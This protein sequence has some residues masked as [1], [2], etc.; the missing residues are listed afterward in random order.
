MKTL[1]NLF[2]M[3]PAGTPPKQRN[4][5]N[6]GLTPLR[7][8]RA[9]G[10]W[11]IPWVLAVTVWAGAVTEASAIWSALFD[12]GTPRNSSGNTP[13]YYYVGDYLTHD[14]YWAFNE[15][16]GTGTHNGFGIKPPSGSWTYYSAD[17]HQ[18]NGAND[19]WKF[20]SDN[21]VQFKTSGNHYYGGRF[22]YGW[23]TC[24][25]DSDWVED[26][27]SSMSDNS[28]FT[29]SAL[30]APTFSSAAKDSTYPS[31]K[32]DLAW[33][34]W[35]SKNVLIVRRTGSDVAWTPTPGATYTDGENL[36]SDTY[37]VKGSWSGTSF[38]DTVSGGTTYYYKMFSENNHYYSAAASGSKS[39][40]T[41]VTTYSWRGEANTAQWDY[42][43]TGDSQHWWDG[44]AAHN[45]P[46]NNSIIR[47][48]NNQQAPNW[49]Q[50][51]SG[52]I[53]H[54][55]FFDD[56]ATT[57]RTLSDQTLTLTDNGGTDPLIQNDSTASHV[58][59]VGLT[60]DATDPMSIKAV[61]GNLT[62][63]GA[64]ANAGQ[65]LNVD[66]ASGKTVTM[67]TGVVSG[68]GGITKAGT[69]TLTLSGANGYTGAIA[70][71][72]GV[73]SAAHNT[74]LGTVAGG[75]TV[76]SGTALQL[77]GG[78]T[79]GAEALSLSGTGVSSAGALRN[80]SGNNTYGGAVTLAASSSVA[81]DGASD[82]LTLSGVVHATASRTLTKIG[83]G[84]LALTANNTFLSEPRIERGTLSIAAVNSTATANQPL[85]VRDA[86]PAFR[87][88]NDV[89]YTGSDMPTLR[90]TG[91]TAS[92]PKIVRIGNAG[93]CAIHVTEAATALT[94]SGR[95]YNGATAARLYKTGSGRLILSSSSS[96][97]SGNT[98]IT[99]GPL[100]A[101]VAEALGN[102][103]SGGNHSTRVSAGGALEIA[104]GITLAEEIHL[105]SDGISS[106]G[107]LR[108]ISGDNTLSGLF[109]LDGASRINSDS[110]T[111]TISGAG[112]IDETYGLTFGG[113]G[114][115]T[116][117]TPINTGANTLTKDGSGTL[118]LNG[119][120]T[121]SG[122]TTISAGTLALGASGT[123]DDTPQIAIAAG[124]T[125]DI[126][127]LGSVLTRN[128]LTLQGPSAS[129]TGAIVAGADDGLTLGATSTTLNLPY[130]SSSPVT[131]PLSITGGNLTLNSA[132]T[133]TVHNDGTALAAGAGDYKIISKGTGGAV[134][135]TTLPSVTVTGNGIAADSCATL[136]VTSGEL[137]IRV[138]T[139]PAQ[140]GT[141]TGDASVCSGSSGNTYSITT[142]SGATGY[143]WAVPS[144]ASITAGQ[145]TTEITVTMGSSSGNISVTA[146]NSCGSSSARTLAVT[147]TSVPSAP[148]VSAESDVTSSGFTANWA[149]SSG[150]TSYELDVMT[151][152][153]SAGGLFISEVT[154][155]GDDISARF[156]ELYNASGADINFGTATWYLSKQVNGGTWYDIQ[157][158]GIA[159]NGATFI[160]AYSVAGFNTAYGEDPEQGHGYINANGDDAY[161][162]YS[163]DDH[164]A[165]TLVDIY[166]AL[167]T[168]GTGE[169]WEYE[170]TH[171]VRDSDINSGSTTWTASEWT[172]PA[173]ADVADMTPH[174]HTVSG[175][176]PIY[177]TSPDYEDLALG[178]VTT[179]PVIG[180]DPSSTYFYWV[181][182][183]N[184][185]GTSENSGYQ[186]VD[187][188]TPTI[189]SSGT[190]GAL[191]T[192]YGTAS[193][194][195]TTFSVS[196]ANM[197]AGILVTPP[198]GFEVSLSSGSGFGATVTVGSSGTIASTPVYLRLSATASAG[199]KSGNIV[200]SSS[201][202]ASANVATTA[203]TIN[204]LAVTLTGSRTYDG[205]T[206]AVY[207]ILTV[208]NQVGS[209]DVTVASGTA[210]LASKNVGSPSISSPGTLALGGADQANYTLTGASGSA[211]IT[212]RALT[213]TAATASKTYDGDTTSATAATL[214]SGVIQSGDSAP[215]WTQSYDTANVGTSKT[216][217][218]SSLVVTDGNSGNNY[219]YTYTPDTVGTITK[220]TP[221]ITTWP[222]ASDILQGEALSDSTLSGGS[223]SVA[224]SFAFISP[225]TT[226]SVGTADQD[227]RFTPTDSANYNTVDDVV[228][229]TVITGGIW[230][231]GGGNDDWDTAANW[232]NDT[233][234]GS[235]HDASFYTGNSSGSSIALNTTYS[236]HSMTFLSGATTPLSFSGSALTIGADGISV[237]AS[238]AAHTFANNIV[239]DGNQSWENASTSVLTVG[240]NISGA[241]SMDKTGTGPLTL[242][243]DNSF[244]GGLTLGGGTL[245]A[246]SHANA[247]GAGD[248]TLSTA[249]T[250]LELLNDTGLTFGNNT[251]VSA[252][253]T[254]ESGRSTSGAGVTHT[255]GTLSMAGDTL[256]VNDDASR[257]SGTAGLTFGT[258][259]LSADDSVFT[260]AADAELT[261][262]ALG[263]SYTWTKSGSG[264]LVLSA[265]AN[266]NSSVRHVTIS[267]GVVSIEDGDAFGTS[268]CD[269]II[270]S[271]GTLE[272]NGPGLTLDGG[273]LVKLND[274]GTFRSVGSNTSRP[275][276][277]IGND[278]TVTLEAAGAS[279]VFT[280]GNGADDITG[281]NSASEIQIS[282]SGT[283][284]LTEDSD[285]I[286]S[287]SLD[288]GTLQI[289]DSALALGSATSE[290]LTLN[291][292]ALK[293]VFGSADSRDF[294]VG[295]GN[296]VIVSAE[297][298]ITAD[299]DSS[300]A[301][302]YTFGT[303]S[304]GAQTLSLE[305][306]S[307]VSSGTAGV[308]FGAI[309]LTGAPTFDVT[310]GGATTEL[311]LGAIDNGVNLL[312]VTGTGDTII[313]GNVGSGATKSGGLT[314]SGTGTLTMSAAS[315][316]TGDTTITAGTLALSTSG[317][318]AS[319]P[320]IAIS[321]GATFSVA[322]LS[323]TLTLASGQDLTIAGTGT[324]SPSTLTTDSGINLATATDSEITFSSFSSSG[325]EPL[326]VSGAGSLTLASGNTVNVTIT[327]GA[328]ANGSYTLIAS[329]VA[330][331]APTTVTLGGDGKSDGAASAELEIS[332][333]ALI[334]H[335]GRVPTVT[336]S[337]ATGIDGTGATLN[338]NVTSGNGTITERGFCYKT[339]S[340]VSISDNKTVKSGTT[341][342]FTHDLTTLDLN[343]R[344][345]WVAYAMNRWGTTLSTPELDFWTLAAAPSAPTV[346]AVSS[347]S[348]SVDVNVNG[349]S[350]V[351]E[352]AI[353]ETSG[354]YVQADGTLDT[355]PEWQTDATWG[356]QNVTGLTV[357]Q[358]Y[359][360][361]VIARNGT[362]GT[363]GIETAFSATA[364]LYTLAIVPSAPTVNNS[365]TSSLDVNVNANGNPVSVTFAIYESSTEEYVQDD[366]TLGA[367]E[368]WQTEAIW[369]TLT[370]TDLDPDTEYTFQVK[371]KNGDGVETALGTGAS[372]STTAA[373]IGEWVGGGVNGN[374]GTA[375]NWSSDT[376]PG[377]SDT[378][379]FY[380]R[381][382][383]GTSLNLEAAKSI[384]GVVFNLL[385]DDA[386]T[387]SGSALTIGADG[388][389]V[390]A[391]AAGAHTFNN[392]IVL[393]AAQEWALGSTAGLTFGGVISGDYTLTKTGTGPLNLNGAN[394][395]EDTLTISAGLVTLGNNAGLGDTA[396]GT[397]V[398]S[399]AALNLNGKTV[400]AEALTLSG[401][402]ISSSGVLYNNSATAASVSGAITLDANSTLGVP[403]GDLTLSGAINEADGS[404][405]VTK[406][407]S[408]TLILSGDNS[409]GG[410]WLVN[411][412]TLK[413]GHASA[414]GATGA[415]GADTI[416]ASGAVLDLNG[417]AVGNSKVTLNGTGISSGGALINSSGTAASLGTQPVTLGSASSIGG[418]GNI[419][420][421]GVFSGSDTLTK[422]GTGTV[423]LA[424]ISS[425]FSSK[426]IIDNGTLEF[427]TA[428]TRLGD[429]PVGVVADQ[430]T[431]NGATL[432]VNVGSSPSF[433]A[434]RGVT[435]GAG[436]ATISVGATPTFTIN[437]AVTGS[438]ALT[439]TGAGVLVLTADNATYSG[440]VTV[441]TGTLR[442]GGA[443]ALSSAN[444]VTVSGTSVLQVN[445]DV[446]IGA[447]TGASGTALRK[448]VTGTQ[449]LT[450]SQTTDTTFAGLIENGSGTLALTKVGSGT[451]T[452]SGSANTYSGATAINAGTLLVSGSSASSAHTVGAAGT[453]A[454]A[455]TV[456][457]L[458][459]NG[460]VSPGNSTGAESTLNAAAI[461]LGAGG[462]YTFDIAN[463]AGTPGT[464]W[465]L[466][467]GTGAL[468]VNASGT[469]TIYLTGNPTGFSSSS[470]YAWTILS[471][472]SVSGF[473]NERFAV[474]VTGFTPDLGTGQF[475]VEQDG[476][477]IQLVFIR[478]PTE[479]ANTVVFTSRTVGGMTVEW[480]GGNGSDSLVI[481]RADA[482][483]SGAP[484][485]GATGYSA[486]SVF[487]GSGTALGDGKIVYMG[488]GASVAVT[489]LAPE[490]E[491][492]A[493]VFEFNGSGV[494]AN[495]FTGIGSGNPNSAYTLS[496]EPSA[497]PA[498]FT[499]T[500]ASISSIN[501][502]WGD[503]TG[504]SGFIIVRQTADSGWT[505]PVG[506]TVYAQGDPL[507][508]GGTVVYAGTADGSGSTTDSYGTMTANTPYYYKIYAYKYDDEAGHATYNYKTDSALAANATTHAAQPAT[509]AHDI[510]IGSYAGATM[511][512]L[513]WTDGGGDG[514]ILVVKEGSEV[515]SFPLDGATYSGNLTFGSG[516]QIGTGN[517]VVNV[518]SGPIT[519]LSG[520]T[521]DTIYHFR[522]FEYSGTLGT[523]ANFLTTEAT[524]NPFS[525]TTVA[526]TPSTPVASDLVADP[527]GTTTAT[528]NW[529]L[530]DGTYALV[531]MKATTSA[532][533]LENPSD[534]TT[535]AANS[536]LGSG[537][538]LGSDTFVVYK[539]SGTSVDVSNLIPGTKYY[540]AVYMFNGSSDGAESYRT[541]DKPTANF[542][543][544]AAEPTQ[545]T[546]ITFDNVATTSMDVEWTNGDG[547]GRIVVA[548]ELD[549]AGAWLM[550]EG[551]GST[552][553]DATVNGNDG[554]FV[555]S[556]TWTTRGDA[557]ALTF[558]GTSQLLEVDDMPLGDAAPT[559]F[560]V[561]LWVYS[562]KLDTAYDYIVFRG[563]NDGAEIGTSIYCLHLH[564]DD[565]VSWAVD[566]RLAEGKTGITT[567]Q[568]QNQWVHMVG[569]Y[570]GTASKFYLNGQLVHT[571][572]GVGAIGNTASGNV[573]GFAGNPGNTSFR[574]FQGSLSEPMIFDRAL[575]LTEIAD[576]YDMTSTGTGW[577]PTDGVA[578]SGVDND[579]SAATDQG[580]NSKIVFNETGT[581]NSVTVTDLNPDT[582]YRFRV[583]EY[584]GS[585]SF[586]NYNTS[587]ATDNPNDQATSPLEPPTEP[588]PSLEVTAWG[589][590]SL[591]LGWSRGNGNNVLV[592]A[593]AIDPA[594]E[595]E[596]DVDYTANATLGS[597]DLVDTA[598]R[599]VYNGTG[600][601]VPVTG[602]SPASLYQF[603]AYEYLDYGAF[604]IRYR[605]A[606]APIADRYT[607]STEPANPVTDFNANATDPASS[608]ELDLTWV[609]SGG[610]PAPDGYIILKRVGTAST[611]A[612]ADGQGYAVGDAVGDG[613]VAAIV[614][615]GTATSATVYGLGAGTA[616]HFTIFPFRWKDVS[617]PTTC[618]Y[619]T[620]GTIPTDWE[621]TEPLNVIKDQFN[622]TGNLSGKDGDDSTST[623]WSDAWS[624]TYP[625]TYEP[626]LVSGSKD[627]P[628]GYPAVAGN[629]VQMSAT[630][631]ESDAFTA[632]RPF[633]AFTS[634]K[635][636]AAA[637]MSHDKSGAGW[638]CGLSLIDT[639]DGVDAERAFMGG[640]T[641]A[642]EVL[643]LSSHGATTVS[644]GETFW[645]GSDK[646]HLVI[647]RYDFT[648]K[649]ISGLIYQYDGDEDVPTSEPETW[650]I[651]NIDI[652]DRIDSDGINAVQ[653]TCGGKGNVFQFDEVR[654]A[655]SWAAIVEAG[656]SQSTD[657]PSVQAA[658]LNVN[659]STIS[660]NKMTL[661][662]NGGN[663][664]NVLVVA[665]TA[666][667]TWTPT[668]NASYTANAEYETTGTEVASGNG[669]YAIYNGSDEKPTINLTELEK[670][671]PYY[672]RAFEYNYE[673]PDRKYLKVSAS[674]NPYSC[675]TLG[676][677]SP[678][679]GMAGN[680]A[681]NLNWTRFVNNGSPFSVLVAY[682]VGSA[683]TFAP[684]DGTAY[685]TGVQGSG[686]TILLANEYDSTYYYHSGF[687]AGQTVHYKFFTRNNNYYSE[688]VARSVSLVTSE[689]LLYDGCYPLSGGINNYSGT[690]GTGWNGNWGV[691]DSYNDA[692]GA[693]VWDSGS[694][695]GDDTSLAAWDSDNKI[696]FWADNDDRDISATRYI[697]DDRDEI[698]SGTYYLSFRM[699]FQYGG[700]YNYAGLALINSSGN[701]EM[702]IG[703][704]YGYGTLFGLD[705]GTRTV[706]DQSLSQGS[707]N[708]YIFVVK[709]VLNASGDDVISAKAYKSGTDLIAEEPTVWPVSVTTSLDNID[710]VRLT[711]GAD[712]GNKIGLT[713]FDEIRLG[714]D[715]T[716]VVRADGEQY[717]AMM[718]EGPLPELI[719]VGA[720]YSANSAKKTNIT[721]AELNDD[722]HYIDVAVRWTSPY[723][724]FLTNTVSSNN[725]A[726][727]YLSG[728]GN[729]MP[730]WDPLAKVGATSYP[731][732]FDKLFTG[733][734]GN[735]GGTV[736][737][738]YYVNAFTGDNFISEGAS[739]KVGDE[740]FITVSGQTYPS[741][742]NK[743][744]ATASSTAEQVPVRRALTINTNLQ[745]YVIDDDPNPPAL[746]G[747]DSLTPTD[748]Q[749]L[750]GAP[751]AGQVKD[752]WSGVDV[753]SLK[754]WLTNS[755]G[756]EAIGNQVF[757]TKPAAD[758]DA[759]QVWGDLAHTLTVIKANNSL[760]TWKISV[761][762]SDMDD[763][764]WEGDKG[765]TN[766]SFEF[767][768]TDDDAVAPATVNMNFPGALM[769]VP[770]I[771]LTNGTAPSDKIRGY[772]ERRSGSN[773][774]N[775]LTRVT[776]ADLAQSF[777]TN[778]QFVFGARDVYSGV[779]RGSTGTTNSVMNFNLGSAVVGQFA[780]YNSSLS[781]VQTATNQILNNYW[782]FANGDFSS[783]TINALMAAGPKP[784]R[785]RI[786]D[787]DDDRTADWSIL[788]TQVGLFDV[789]DDDIRGPAISLV[790][791]EGIMDPSDTLFTSFEAE[792]GD[793]VG[794]PNAFKTLNEPWTINGREWEFKDIYLSSGE[795]YSG[796]QRI[797]LN[798]NII[799]GSW[800]QLP[801]SDSPR[802]LSFMASRAGNEAAAN[803]D[804]LVQS[805]EA[806][807]WTT[808]ATKTITNSYTT[809]GYDMYA[810]DLN[811]SGVVTLR[812]FRVESDSQVYLDDLN[813]MPMPEWSNTNKLN[814]SWT[815]AVDDFSGIDEYRFLSP[816]R[817]TTS[818]PSPAPDIGVSAA[819]DVTNKVI[820][821]SADQD[822]Q[823]LL[824]GYVFSIDGDQ[825][826]DDD[827]SM[828]TVR[829][830][831]AR[832]DRTPPIKVP[833]LEA[834]TDT[835]DDPTTQFDLQWNK[836]TPITIGPDD[837][838]N[839]AYPSWGNDNKNLLSPWKSYKVY[840]SPYN[841]S[842][843]PEAAA[844]VPAYFRDTFFINDAYKSWDYVTT[845]TAVQD[846]TAPAN[847]YATLSSTGTETTR[848]YDL[849]YDQDYVVAI[850]GVDEAGNEGPV[851]QT[852]WA[853]NNTIRFA[854]IR[855]VNM[856][857]TDAAAAQPDA[858]L[859]NPDTE[860]ASALY[861]IAAG[862]TNSEGI[863]TSVR[864][865]YDL[866]SWDST[867][868]EERTNNNWQLVGTVQSNWFVDDGGQFRSRGQLR[869]YRAS[870]QDRWKKT[871]EVTISNQ[872]VTIDQRPL[873]SE[874][875]YAL[876]NAVLSGGQNF[877]ALHGR[878]YTN[879]FEAVFGGLENFPGG[880]TIQPESGSTVVEFFSPGANA[881]S[882]DQFWLNSSGRWWHGGSDVT[883][884]VMG[885][886]FFSR[887]FSINLPEDLPP[888]YVTTTAFDNSTLD[889]NGDPVE[890]DA[891]V[892]SPIM[893]V[894]TNDF[895]QVISTGS[896]GTR[897]NPDVL[898]Y[899]VA[900]L[901]LPV[902]AHPSEMNLLDSGFVNGAR[903]E[904]DEI[905]TMNTATK[906]VRS[907]STIYCD[908][909]TVWRFVADNSLVPW[910]YFE[911]NDVIVIVSRNYVANGSWTWTY[912]ASDFYDPPTRWMGN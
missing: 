477:N 430:L 228:S 457:N 138:T 174:A 859:D 66:A 641:G 572:S 876:H 211:T 624:V 584:K 872:T 81:V 62:F 51:K 446:T 325:G 764:G 476:N 829:S 813:V 789:L 291:G 276:I 155:P 480:S 303:M 91:A 638:Y 110:G 350:S 771:V 57:A 485:D 473:S 24:Y 275:D 827:R 680:T 893:K 433:S 141:I 4:A 885:D 671:T 282:G 252:D 288:S 64:I 661:T 803:V 151:S 22:Q 781:T 366:G 583:F 59:S 704:V 690:G 793:D 788:E 817:I 706:S 107:A 538:N 52:L 302:L 398:A 539:G 425:G 809:F 156:V 53:V 783:D 580:F 489:G 536:V 833:D 296:H 157:L 637:L 775:I 376:L 511:S 82:T 416:V 31:T 205:T 860:M 874:E 405:D 471:G 911:P 537:A 463:V 254:I 559:A 903:G 824:E 865:E 440:N 251:T 100:R 552:V 260:V 525:Q 468:T 621:P 756:T 358:E 647:I 83:P 18:P 321:G 55:L 453:L 124:A 648:S 862:P 488:D 738:S 591:T 396:E 549:A 635:I 602:L 646:T 229:V 653:F 766:M 540:F 240:G 802:T 902:A 338:G 128:S 675:S 697:A 823:G 28:Y 734:V 10:S 274:G 491:Y 663:G 413:V 140:P 374:W 631:A 912:S 309:T 693:A 740:Y 668:D 315:S 594:E 593:N 507:G 49:Y 750:V 769:N 651:N 625:T 639:T 348:L 214:T 780:N 458:T 843:V 104:G 67:Q 319:S 534:K 856:K 522:V 728:L 432:A 652:G 120:S 395:F 825:D 191:S 579:F 609:A 339:S 678:A 531:T 45:V 482:A 878:P 420:F 807:I 401:T 379:T 287:W 283:V 90:Y 705:D 65:A 752:A 139:K 605:L 284:K 861:W 35:N 320:V 836:K 741:T 822:Q 178:N 721:D 462:G 206:D 736:A 900:A 233:I 787:S 797:G 490:T 38:E 40:T 906:G 644:S 516:T 820:D 535:Y 452:I 173:S 746:R 504:E 5:T 386:L 500:A 632:R 798:Q 13:E 777:T 592:V 702:F 582:L 596:D 577:E 61:S 821:L 278:A 466:V 363:P 835:V 573:L 422:V 294:T 841:A 163:G 564:T 246:T 427:E 326:A 527:I 239:L 846:V 383:S 267:A 419:T 172:I 770:F 545:A 494:S 195:P 755:A 450:V 332:G 404:K 330:G 270:N 839:A 623:G 518:G 212:A 101:T 590:H 426:I 434:N 1:F 42:N 649:K 400:G 372:E 881:P 842:L 556:P 831:A 97:Y 745:F 762:A 439:K 292:G 192:T 677:P 866:I 189:S 48:D 849:D 127:A 295:Q 197:T 353:Q 93:Y 225:A 670:D 479:Q 137:F 360:F 12:R 888:A 129:G 794:W 658:N 385:A 655:D 248:L 76:A 481:L 68:S 253:V 41:D 336:S 497:H 331:T 377:A 776:D 308:T 563:A 804:V 198:S 718:E 805:K 281:G 832:I 340:G 243:G 271:G 850:V 858:V 346:A 428:E 130:F 581:D 354:D 851:D 560:S 30:G 242:S 219:S 617:T 168:D 113:S 784:V 743:V 758:G 132:T 711:A 54:Q 415:S 889:E 316:Y 89:S 558:S 612:P 412:G 423:K 95:L 864:K 200:L 375:A 714:S 459:I 403:S 650:A 506:G 328:L 106:G 688:G 713:Y 221:T 761:S 196:G 442:L 148:T 378:A 269:V 875:V 879:T 837:P 180:L 892:W 343:T 555:G 681:A 576:L 570:D 604:G 304:I 478:E 857:K 451:L 816:S 785:V 568:I 301:R 183:V 828:G 167:N 720:T 362:G 193:A 357:N 327:G 763:D 613:T 300:A 322:G 800:V 387:F 515:D 692:N 213:I 46:A 335:C 897:P 855:G 407:G 314:K 883:T 778:L 431:I 201:D 886:D 26:N 112:A 185:C 727:A 548:T 905:Y 226:P 786:P 585:G 722:A 782:T 349:N 667:I 60:G 312:T 464:E 88:G 730:N 666:E 77:S 547:D 449:T 181:R 887:G 472:S 182:A 266:G 418:S 569:T 286:G 735:N 852:S 397:E 603:A 261:L 380:T 373:N 424:G 799:G 701:T 610:S 209:D 863:Y 133:V 27:V 521:A 703:N 329:G 627:S 356:T 749:M 599:A 557:G 305:A 394:T 47:V 731:L 454:G 630:D 595:P 145:N 207:S 884:N 611:G 475:S 744:A 364:S 586:I 818:L 154:D 665:S 589:T 341:G 411:A 7:R 754:F 753:S 280:I 709:L 898:V 499:A 285:Y 541:G 85:G 598:S 520:L 695:P 597:G 814:I 683:V 111:L 355:D 241:Y 796:S 217:T 359:T 337:A 244:S 838:G 845:A 409:L 643:A 553:A 640:A 361:K 161:F 779:A 114:H 871:R 493:E 262:G 429:V 847:P 567:A 588:A 105:A 215:T 175:G 3:R 868:F 72:A 69:G 870:Y 901:R 505:V 421:D 390:N 725:T 662:V 517:Y 891:M 33:S 550:E 344:Y 74:A 116:I 514:R 768:V 399:G 126:S 259:T 231:G 523:T 467:S 561:S 14:I 21:T 382:D 264:T 176:T 566:G 498:S 790:N 907:G 367:S 470:S 443:S 895:S 729:A 656:G 408:G 235:A 834:S 16:T 347:V 317:A 293:L 484:T 456:G 257:T 279:D 109:N 179:Y 474:D 2:S 528:L 417:T 616:Y 509:Q 256:T 144:G 297:S 258:T 608:T 716:S 587:V 461:T 73:L 687:T 224:G 700:D 492:Y 273:P 806:G 121:Y 815:E 699:N 410:D 765:T 869:F 618:N 732:G 237:V 904:S 232:S 672:F 495:Y 199:A 795:K 496:T 513:N 123:I 393:G 234:P 152:V 708:D 501:L 739:W 146:D 877:V 236:I 634:G 103:A 222:T 719:Y 159:T 524:G 36:G 626:T 102:T 882:S 659:N 263:G 342:A 544:L 289:E 19:E 801:P 554:A 760:D 854:L 664:N 334:L 170:D 171:A 606:D 438:S 384:Q 29:V 177:V 92:T 165:G 830:L 844:A 268:G 676:P 896:Q 365:T 600:T 909:D 184:D 369:D 50:N 657:V 220:A 619:K 742:G 39:V 277:T 526:T 187:T 519:T 508:A 131:A 299:S 455:G 58:I 748:H 323:S 723:G 136:V 216:M 543:A 724:L 607:L 70:I 71:N 679:V 542:F 402:G 684:E 160:I 368:V 819:A 578:P 15:D 119:T 392:A 669:V 79:I 202:A 324:G 388:I 80:V 774:T 694:I 435:L 313:T 208:N 149:A 773:A 812:L 108:N 614:T 894:P 571:D 686:D 629:K 853:T 707:G 333:G 444:S 873:A 87:L 840:Y 689:M 318:I 532:S 265:A 125:F 135:A 710:R 696:K 78:I 227:V 551:S 848:L 673:S 194:P 381:T 11:L 867:R 808:K 792:V 460:R 448:S 115:V 565:E 691:S 682:R 63:N 502:A 726:S 487:S 153:G 32:I 9:S 94:L 75:V 615:D 717:L 715:W 737:T 826:R 218:P 469:F 186:E 574:N 37:V 436:G 759:Q 445:A 150:A 712:S 733:F 533:S 389:A 529:T 899:N 143:T 247:L 255:L 23:G 622:Y 414:L 645:G 910:V 223:A 620:D 158:S 311:T 908:P 685:S 530:G 642:G 34:Q 486:D 98:Y 654:V 791:I 249:S 118:T 245:R 17:Y 370:V 134:V 465:D 352:F 190:P 147:V 203:S 345:Y 628:A 747:F 204:Q 166:G 406:T 441:S 306:G 210:T 162:L 272:L 890:V 164:T 601:T 290:Q 84:I 86:T 512:T 811:L 674:A 142:V 188:A 298:T 8:V 575:T 880:T 43:G 546:D 99:A 767:T 810:C 230:D 44:S 117:S 307:G 351:T 6:Q 510:T 698:S 772:I 169:A 56:G 437:S 757:S 238:S 96:D 250:V 633:P 25:A 483:P 310:E 660:Q 562:T 503:A 751:V 122:N 447:L 391:G 371:A 636:Y 20:T